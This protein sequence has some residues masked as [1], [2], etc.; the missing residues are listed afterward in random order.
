MS[1]DM[2]H[3]Y[4][5]NIFCVTDCFCFCDSDQKCP[6]QTRSVSHSNRIDI[7]QCHT[8]ICKSLF[9]YLIYFFNMLTGSDFRHHTTIQCV[10]RNLRR[11]HVRTQ[12]SSIYN[13]SCCCLIAR[14]L[15]RKYFYFIHFYFL[16]LRMVFNI[17]PLFCSIFVRIF[18]NLIVGK[19]FPVFILI[20]TQYIH[21]VCLRKTFVLFYEI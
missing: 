21:L 14:A 18:I 15:D 5:G 17:L 4:Q 10:Q 8:C 12:I 19:Y 20:L 3:S 1:L 6:H 9:N 7:V 2:M 13:D 16:L 11:D